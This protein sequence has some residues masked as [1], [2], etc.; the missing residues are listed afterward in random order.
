MKRAYDVIV[1]GGGHAGCEAAAAAARAGARTLLLTH[2]FDTIGVMSCNPAIGGI[3][4]GHL[5]REI[6]ALDGLMGIAADHAGIHFK[7]L[8]RSKGP[9]V[10]GPR[11]Q[12]DRTL[13]RLAI[14]DL[15]AC[16][17]GLD[18]VE[19]AAGDLLVNAQGGVE[20][21]VC[22]DGRSFASGAVVLATGTFLRGTIHIGH[23]SEPAGRV[24]DR[25]ANALGRRLA[26]LGLR[27]GRLK[28]GTPA[29]IARDSIEWDSL[30]ED[31]GDAVPE[32]FSRMTDAITNPMISC[33]ITATTP[34]THEIIRENLQLSALYGGAIS[35]RGPRYCPSI[36]DKVVR[37]AQRESHQIFLEPEGLPGNP[38]GA[39]VYPNGISTSL[40]EH[41]QLEMLRSIPGLENCR[42]VRPG[43][44]VEYDYVDPRELAP[45][46][47]LKNLPGLFLAGQVN[48]TTGYEEAG[49][50]GLIAGI[51]AARHAAGQEGVTLARGQAY[52]GVMIDDLTTQGVS[53]PYRMFTSRAE[54][55]LTLR[56]DNADLR[57]TPLGLEWGCVGSARAAR[58][59]SDRTAIDAAMAR[60]SSE[61]CTPD[62]LRR[63]GVNVSADGR[64]RSLMDVLATDA[65]PEII[66]RIAPWFADLPP[67]V[68]QHLMTEARYSGYIARQE[69]E[70]RQ[71]ASESRIVLPADLDY[72]QI[73][74]LS[75][76][77]QERLA[78]VRPVTFGAAQRI[79]G[80]TPSALVA[81]L[82]H[83][84]HRPVAA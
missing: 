29:R 7:L 82:A 9:A 55:R 1:V 34:R 47:E 57:L 40:P 37:F 75:T 13:Y 48:G 35:G 28:T 2:R 17:E 62:A 60:A 78:Q 25:P 20:G 59:L 19:G 24:G 18:I 42:M 14:Q 27:M 54:Y 83:V 64:A 8:N 12:A 36:E 81:L 5:V 61:T 30:A 53:E 67:R 77:M 4:K 84:R 45:T 52:I 22:E 39:L 16:T 26:A 79:P 66:T 69:R 68:A 3:G 73:G 21:V 43:Y 11:A 38:D 32:A 49:A 46:L 71:L 58:L 23:E 72:H 15:L 41:V 44:A 56:A 65:T 80:I 33:R 6:D 31:R 63:E 70:I 50:Q 51:N 76:E 74:G 10:H